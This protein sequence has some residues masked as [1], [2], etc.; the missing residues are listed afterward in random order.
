MPAATLDP[1]EPLKI[2]GCTVADALRFG[3]A[4]LQMQDDLRENAA[5]DAQQ[6]L[7]IA[8]G[9]TRV[10]M[11]AQPDRALR[12][13]EAG[14]FQGMVAQRRGGVPVQ[15]M[16]GSQEFFARS[17]FVTPDVLIPRP[18]TEGIVEEVLRRYTD[19]STPLRIADV[20]TGSGI[21]AVTLALEY[22]A[23][24]VSAL[25]ISPAAL[26]VARENAA[27]LGARNVRFRESDLLDAAGDERFDLIVSNPPYIPLSEVAEL[28]RQV[29]DHEPHLALFGGE[30]G[31]DIIRELL[32]QAA[33]HLHPGGWLLMET[34]GRSAAYDALL[35]GWQQVRWVRDLQGIE[36]VVVA[37]N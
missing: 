15:H 10:Q 6:I 30:D 4:R 35:Q 2:A 8:T 37:R 20:G 26:V 29:R 12:E 31:L 7:E 24:D 22:P 32:P 28:H 18:E 36:R 27:A 21:L 25:D 5:R 3:T 33:A 34:A 23:S 9:L 13:E 16:R 14:S 11:L 1:H 19:R 17:F